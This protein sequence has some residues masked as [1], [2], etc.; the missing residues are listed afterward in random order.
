[1]PGT[2]SPHTSQMTRPVSYSPFGASGDPETGSGA[3][4]EAS[5][6]GGALRRLC[7]SLH[8]VA[9]SRIAS[10]LEDVGKDSYHHTL[11]E[12]LGNWSFGDYFKVHLLV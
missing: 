9:L 6:S 2:P 7:L 8:L 5:P 12:M 11:F 3:V 1:M 4:S 10:D